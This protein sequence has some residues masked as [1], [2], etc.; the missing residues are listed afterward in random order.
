MSNTSQTIDEI[1]R[2]RG[3]S[4]NP[5]KGAV[6]LHCH[7]NSTQG[8]TK[9]DFYRDFNDMLKHVN[10]YEPKNSNHFWMGVVK[11]PHITLHH[12]FELKDYEQ[13]GGH[14][15]WQKDIEDLLEALNK[16]ESNENNSFKERMLHGRF[17]GK[18]FSFSAN[19]NTLA[20]GE[21][22]HF[23]IVLK[24]E[25]PSSEMVKFRDTLM[26]V[27]PHTTSFTKW[28][29]HMSLVTVANIESRDYLLHKLKDAYINISG[30]KL[31]YNIRM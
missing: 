2:I 10:I 19:P 9:D 20:A 21:D 24:I 6:M 22:N 15:D 18:P 5:K 31:G 30:L 26:K 7:P 4:I 1:N 3:W 11:Q 25:E 8:E 28:S 16:D 12:G 14:E 13:Q 17:K 23:T 29:A 27:F